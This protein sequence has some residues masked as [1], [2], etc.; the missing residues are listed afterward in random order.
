DGQ[1]G[2]PD[3]ADPPPLRDEGVVGDED[4][5]ALLDRRRDPL[6]DRVRPLLPLLPPFSALKAWGT[7]WW[8][9]HE[10]PASGSCTVSV[11]CHP[12]SLRCRIRLRRRG[13]HAR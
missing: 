8:F 7:P 13:E 12:A 6:R 5:G 4:H 1:A 3:R 10:L 11:G 9:P 2:L